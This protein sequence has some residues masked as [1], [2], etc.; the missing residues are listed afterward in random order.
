[1]IARVQHHGGGGP[2]SEHLLHP[3]H[4]LLSLEARKMGARDSQNYNLVQTNLQNESSMY[5]AVHNG[6]NLE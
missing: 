1:V 2:L 6:L 4:F 5:E 3:R